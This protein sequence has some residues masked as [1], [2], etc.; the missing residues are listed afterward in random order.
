M[1][2]IAEHDFEQTIRLST[3]SV[4]PT[5]DEDYFSSSFWI[6]SRDEGGKRPIYTRAKVDFSVYTESERPVLVIDPNI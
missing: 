5:N 6:F 1:K 2:T 4:Q 3:M